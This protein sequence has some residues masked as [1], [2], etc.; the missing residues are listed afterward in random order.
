MTEPDLTAGSEVDSYCLKCKDMTN[1][2]IIAM[3]DGAIAKAQCNVCGGRHKYRAAK[4][5]KSKAKGTASRAAAG[6]T[7]KEKKA[8]AAFEA[9]LK[10]RDGSESKPYAMTAIF[11][12]NEIINH[13]TFGLGV[14]TSIIPANKIEVTF[15]DGVR[16][17]ICVLPVSETPEPAKSRK[18]KIRKVVKEAAA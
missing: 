11:N 8:T 13:P 1:H 6:V 10:G 4:P 3:A 9:L 7:L 12:K 5:S 16:I 17:L 14:V 15:K 18:K 2:M